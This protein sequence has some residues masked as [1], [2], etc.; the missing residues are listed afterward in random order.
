MS[1]AR[2]DPYD[3][4][5]QPMDSEAAARAERARRRSLVAFWLLGLL[6]NASF[7]IMIASAKSIA[8]GGVGFVKVAVSSAR[9][10]QKLLREQHVVPMLLDTLRELINLSEADGG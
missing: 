4:M 9:L 8:S 3:Q 1:M 6:N 7:V 2:R 5:W 10:Y